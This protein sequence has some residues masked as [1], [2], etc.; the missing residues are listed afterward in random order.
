MTDTT[1]TAVGGR[2]KGA[3][4]AGAERGAAESASMGREAFESPFQAGGQAL[5]DNCEK[6]LLFNKERMETTM[7]AFQDWDGMSDAGRKTM[8]AWLASGRIAAEGWTEITGR[9]AGCFA[10]AVEGGMAASEKALAC[11]DVAQL[12]DLQSREALRVMDV[13]M[14]DGS[15][16]SEMTVKTATA[17]MAPI[18]DRV[19]AAVADWIRPTP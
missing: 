18:A 12:A 9:M 2:A 17:A 10:A 19:N 6:L 4:G 8:E 3:D 16:L 7:K 14:T 13:W 5:S 1:G 11:K 15:A